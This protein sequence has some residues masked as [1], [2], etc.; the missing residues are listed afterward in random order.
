MAKHLLLS[1]IDDGPIAIWRAP[2]VNYKV[3]GFE[4][5]TDLDAFF[6]SFPKH[7]S[8]GSIVDDFDDKLK[9]IKFYSLIEISETADLKEFLEIL[10][11][12]HT[13]ASDV[14]SQ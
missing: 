8:W 9:G 3:E 10:R 13:K 11:N 7:R 12:K 14:D 5:I 2:R 4:D 1:T 6:D